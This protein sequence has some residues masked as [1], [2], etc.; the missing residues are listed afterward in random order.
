VKI[1]CDS[2][3]AAA[4]FKILLTRPVMENFTQ[5]NSEKNFGGMALAANSGKEIGIQILVYSY[6]K[7]ISS[8]F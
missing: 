6:E 7:K 1:L 5:K 8:A 2:R 4:V 3:K